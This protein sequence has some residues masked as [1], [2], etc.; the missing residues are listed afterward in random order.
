ME[1]IRNVVE[2]SLGLSTL[3]KEEFFLSINMITCD[4]DKIKSTTTQVSFKGEHDNRGDDI[5]TTTLGIFTEEGKEYCFLW[6]LTDENIELDGWKVRYNEYTY[7][8]WEND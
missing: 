4:E 2:F 3:A 6:K 5:E 7:Y 8:V 1:N